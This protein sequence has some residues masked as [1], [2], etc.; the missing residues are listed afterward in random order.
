MKLE[1]V[2]DLKK[3]ND[4]YNGSVDCNSCPFLD[5]CNSTDE[6]P[7]CLVEKFLGINDSEDE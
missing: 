7:D 3:L 1:K 4:W 6:F 5:F 2:V